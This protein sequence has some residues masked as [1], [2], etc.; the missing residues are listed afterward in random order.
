MKQLL[1]MDDVPDL[2]RKEVGSKAAALAIMHSSGL[3]VPRSLFVPAKLYRD[4]LHNTGLRDLILVE[5]GRKAFEEMRWEEMWDTAL[6]IRNLFL[7]TPIPAA[8]K[9]EISHSVEST[10]H[11]VPVAV[12]SSALAEDTTGASFAGLHESY[13]NVRGAAEI[14]HHMVLVWASLWSDAALLYRQ[15]LGLSIDDSAM[16]VIVQEMIFGQKSG[17]AFG[18][19]P[20]N[21]HHAIVESVYGLNKGL[22]DGDVEPDRWILDRNTGSVLSNTEVN[23]EKFIRPTSSGVEVADLDGKRA[24]LPP[25]DEKELAAVFDALRRLESLFGQP[26]DM[27]WTIQHDTLTVLQ[28]RP[29][30]TRSDEDGENRAWYLSLRRSFSNL[31]ELGDRIEGE[32][33]PAMEREAEALSNVDIQSMDNDAL[34]REIEQRQAI[35]D[36]WRNV[37]WEEFI[38][39]AH[40]ARL[41]GQ[42]YNNRLH[43]QDP[44]EFIALLTSKSMMSVQRNQL[45]RR[46]AERIR[47]RL[48]ELTTEEVL[49]DKELAP[50]IELLASEFS[51]LT[52]TMYGD[53]EEK[54]ALARLLIQL[55]SQDASKTGAANMEREEL[56]KRYMQSFPD[57]ERDYA[58][59]LLEL[60]RKSYRLRDDDN[61]YLGRIESELDRAMDQARS[62]LNEQCPSCKTCTNAEELI[63]TL[64]GK[65]MEGNGS[66]ASVPGPN[67]ASEDAATEVPEVAMRL[68]ARQLKGQPAGQGLARAKARVVETNEDLFAFQSGEILVCDA[69]D[70]NMT[71]VVPLAAGIVERRGGMLIHGA[72]I[73]REYGLPCVTGIPDATRYIQTGDV[74]TVDGYYGLVIIHT[75]TYSDENG[76]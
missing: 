61:L 74:I 70:P 44:F 66:D 76:G 16:G 46:T 56:E 50:E 52:N 54:I 2:I 68:Q 19:A 4:F 51:T 33:L 23:R 10:F 53:G 47:P 48:P 71:F 15:E 36:R 40:G 11:E 37:Y 12:R 29:V 5:L 32:L 14:I 58:R 62:S 18:V 39:F 22:V 55:A 43:P 24:S 75:G 49:Q 72:I 35:L 60:G 27:E 34:A 69:I 21:A 45:L 1:S 65:T 41:F 28:S 3:Q 17:V 59:E 31:Q 25:L 8:L 26:Q 73:A 38:P 20:D 67:E 13:L 64:K 63:A 42:V 57:D 9:E 7:N 6:R 30:T